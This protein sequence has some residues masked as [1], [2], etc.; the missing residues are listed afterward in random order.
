VFYSHAV[1]GSVIEGFTLTGGYDSTQ[2]GG[3]YCRGGPPD[4]VLNCVFTDN[5]SDGDGGALY[6]YSS[7]PYLTYCVF[8][9]NSADHGGALYCWES[10]PVILSST[11]HGNTAQGGVNAGGAAIYVGEEGD[12]DPQIS[13]TIIAFGTQG[14]AV[15]CEFGSGVD[16][17]CCDIYGNVGGDYVDCISGMQGVDGNF[18]EDP[19]FCDA[20][21]GD[22]HLRCSSPCLH[23]SGCQ[24]VGA[25]GLGADCARVWHVPMDVPTIQAGI[26]SACA[27]DTVIVASGIYHEHN[28][29][30]KSGICLF[31][32]TGVPEDVVVDADS[33]GRVFL[34]D[35]LDSLTLIAGF[36]ITGGC[37]LYSMTDQ[38]TGGGMLCRGGSPRI[39]HCLFR[40]NALSGIGHP[41]AGGALA[42]LDGCAPAITDCRFVENVADASGPLDTTAGGGAFFSYNSLAT[43]VNCT[44][45]GN[46]ALESGKGGG[47]A[48]FSTAAITGCTFSGN[49]SGYGGGAWLEDTTA[50]SYCAFTGNLAS[51]YGGGLE[52][53]DGPLTIEYSAI[54]GN[55]AGRRGG[56]AGCLGPSTI[57]HCTISG[58]SLGESAEGGAGISCEDTSLVLLDRTI[59]SF[60]ING[61]AVYCESM[62]AAS[63]TCCD[64][65][66]NEWGDY[67]GCIAGQNGVAGNIWGDPLFC[68]P[69]SGDFTI[70]DISPCAAANSPPGCE[71]IGLYDVGCT[72]TAVEQNELASTPSRFY[73]GPAVPNPFNPVTQI[74]YGIPTGSPPSRVVM[75]VY[76]VAGRHV[77]TL[78]DA[79]H[80]PGTYRV[81]WDGRDHQGSEA[82]SGLY[83]Y[84]ITWNEKSETRRM[85]LLK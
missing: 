16:L 43:L 21:G 40:R 24:Q 83:F 5:H 7:S 84:R 70:Q 4:D 67:V 62:S 49:S 10:A 55:S 60:S 45:I 8:S 77:T 75:K 23:V 35:D 42:C 76:D 58:N 34:C 78:V 72:G 64:I 36:T 18:S 81:V 57:R 2:G 46:M 59:V 61:E 44:F 11:F 1:N 79:D 39:I 50:V 33:L 51:R 22:F 37:D 25:F 6:C 63:L 52:C 31:G 19:Q 29:V 73:L 14:S 69:D 38:G 12:D 48:A 41:T 13:Q 27:G 80:N 53:R 26:D 47:L 28:I 68:E 30:M 65:F 20:A 9:G 82:A 66:G 85:V 54:C 71:L 3:W 15:Q 56:G 32:E 17:V 74:Q